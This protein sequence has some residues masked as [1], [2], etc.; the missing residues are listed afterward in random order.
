MGCLPQSVV[1]RK[2]SRNKRLEKRTQLSPSRAKH[3]E[4][5]TNRADFCDNAPD[6]R[7][8]NYNAG[9]WSPIHLKV[10]ISRPDFLLSPP[11]YFC[12]TTAQLAGLIA[13]SWHL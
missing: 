1:R 5:R 3:Q 11:C 9:D 12:P 6:K 7:V 10:L 8:D 2:A 4:V 13:V